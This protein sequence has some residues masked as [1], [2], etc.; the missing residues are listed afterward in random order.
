MERPSAPVDERRRRL[1]LGALAL[2]LLTDDARAAW[3]ARPLR[4]VVAYPP[5]GVSDG[6]ARAL[7]ERLAR[8]MGVHVVVDHRAGAGGALALELLS[9][10]APDGHTLCFTAITALSIPVAGSSALSAG[11][12]PVAGVMRT[13]SLVVGTPALHARDFAGMLDAARARPGDVRW[14]TTGEGTTGFRVLDR[15]RRESGL[16]IVHV[17]YKGG[18]QQLNDALAGHF[19]VLSTNVATQQLDAIRAGRF[20]PLA[21]GSPSRLPVLPQVP[22]LQELGHPRANLSS[23]FGLFAPEGTPVEVVAR[24]NAEIDLALKEPG[25]RRRLVEMNNVPVHGSAEHF[26]AQIA[27]DMAL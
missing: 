1:L 17:P 23:L 8:Q 24:L 9:R 22:T 2:G 11:I 26:A 19:E 27:S 7:A 12:V 13:P 20:K 14:A 16:D 5:G 18:G 3:P 6:V 21:V 15:I 25:L 4:I 10:S